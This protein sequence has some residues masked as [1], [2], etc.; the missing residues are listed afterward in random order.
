MAGAS[1]TGSGSVP[2]TVRRTVT[3]LLLT[4]VLAGSGTAAAA[5]RPIVPRGGLGAALHV[6]RGVIQVPAGH[7]SG[8]TRVVVTLALP[9]LAVARGGFSG[10]A[11]AREKL[12]TS[13]LSSRAYLARV[14]A[15]QQRAIAGLQQAIPEARV[16]WRYRI[17][18]D[19]FTVSLPVG[20]LSR[21][22]HL[23]FVR[24]VY[25][26]L[27][28]ELNLNR[29]PSV[30]GAPA[31]RQATG[32]DGRGVKIAVIDGGVDQTN[33]FLSP[34]G[35]AYPPGFPKGQTKYTTP[36]VIVARS[37][38]GPGSGSAG[39]L[40]TGTVA[41]HGTH[42]AGIAAG[43]SGTTAPAGPDHP[44]VSGLAGVAPGA[45]IGN[46]RVFNVPQPFLDTDSAET[47]EIVRAFESA[48][49]DGMDV[50]NFSGGGPESEPS[51]DALIQT[52][53]NVAKA[54]VV[55]VISAGNDRDDLGLG[56][57]GSPGTA[58]D[59]ITVAAVT[60]AHT[61][62]AGLSVT[63]PALAAPNPLPFE[64]A[65]GGVP[66]SWVKSD[67]K[68]V[69]IGTLKGTDGQP[70]DPHLCGPAADPEAQTSPLAAGSLDG[71]V[72]LVSRGMCS[73]SSQAERVRAAGGIGV[74]FVDNRPGDANVI[75][76]S[77][78]SPGGMISDL[79]G[80]RLRQA[81]ATSGGTLTFRIQRGPLEIET[82]RSG[83]TTSFSSAGPTPFEHRLKPDISAPG[84]Q[85]LSSTLPSYA[86]EPFAVFDGTSMA[87]PH[88][89]GSA[90]LL[91]QLHPTWTPAQVKSALMSTAGAAYADTARTTEASVLLEGAGLASLPAANDPKIFTDVQSLSFGD[92]NVTGGA[93]S[94]QLM[95]TLSDAGGGAGTWQAELQP[96]QASAG[97]S[98][99]LPGPLL[100]SP[101]GTTAFQ[102]TA[103]AAA[104]AP[105]G[106]DYGFLVLRQG[107]VVRR[108]P[109]FF[110][111]T[112][113]QLAADSVMP[114]KKLQ[115]GNTRQGKSR[116]SVYRWPSAPFGTGLAYDGKP[117]VDENGA[118]HVYSFT[119]SGKHTNVGVA[120]VAQ[121]AN[122][123][124]DPWFLGRLDENAV[125]GYAGTPVNVNSSMFD[126]LLP[127]EAAGAVFPKPGRYYVAVDSGRD[128]STGR[129]LAGSYTLRSWI[130]DV[131]P[132][133]VT[134]LTKQVATGR[135]TIA[136]RITD[137]KS[138]VDP[139]SIVLGY[140]QT[141][142][143]ASLYDQGSGIALIAIPGEAPALKAGKPRILVSASDIQE[144]KNVNTIGSDV[145]PNTAFV[146]PRVTV[147][148]GPALTWLLPERRACVAGSEQLI[149]LTSD[150]AEISSVA[151]FDGNKTI[152]RVR[153]GA[154][155]GLY[156]TNWSTARA[157]SGAHQLR[158]VLSDL[159]GRQTSATRVVRVCHK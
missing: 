137:D 63:S 18:L 92:L 144:S 139:A 84:D 82:D 2:Q 158:A 94:R 124:I 8:R 117:P 78:G 21:L 98:V 110:S 111:V 55:P 12:N 72:A 11:V 34:R 25:P 123:L 41:F 96:Q 56:T 126:Y 40:A 76:I 115:S 143:P 28:Y 33:A 100:L 107:D 58:G 149:V 154:A 109:Y 157:G 7:A 105:A 148:K 121:S 127:V 130:D 46:Y 61:F 35:Y 80:A 131:K 15:A 70:V 140:G 42:V 49:A 65:P 54:G 146:A 4:T 132:P 50:I 136:V 91:L 145:M 66:D 36:K 16:S 29:S 103:S 24:T 83:V 73:V 37:F 142:L 74:V 152:A 38:P 62:G 97:A 79:D 39:T 27:R 59:A 108:L 64:P 53:A 87:A 128:D 68:L 77:L 22:E 102:V 118:E 95:V 135:P 3:L 106:D 69:D 85:I 67:A 81:M 122:S 99:A 57:V 114:L 113:P 6:R 47:P 159:A 44:T 101:G 116:A 71:K 1:L 150:S 31:L 10:F 9:P 14:D 134:L 141:L 60:N 20:R 90:A 51:T 19:G 129:S 52:I 138:G 45:W 23:G 104:N 17:L 26:S 43:D 119:V 125:Q 75:P 133:Q 155:G 48:V 13:S 30:I 147:A 32:A 153:T 112:R 93:Q 156:F 151:F 120:V 89:A 86:H 88:I 5:L